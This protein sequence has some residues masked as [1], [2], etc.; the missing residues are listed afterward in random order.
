MFVDMVV[1]DGAYV[2]VPGV[3][4]EGLQQAHRLT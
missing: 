2:S 1:P 4:Q 3:T